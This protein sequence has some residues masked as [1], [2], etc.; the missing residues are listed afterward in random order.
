[1]LPVT[2]ELEGKYLPNLPTKEWKEMKGSY[3]YH[4]PEGKLDFMDHINR[5]HKSMHGEHAK[6]R[7]TLSGINKHI[8][9]N[10]TDVC[11]V[12]SR[13]RPYIGDLF[14]HHVQ[15]NLNGLKRIILNYWDSFVLIQDMSFL[16]SAGV[17]YMYEFEIEYKTL[18]YLSGSQ[19]GDGF[20]IFR[21]RYAPSTLAG[22]T[23]LE[24]SDALSLGDHYGKI[25]SV[26]KVVQELLNNFLLE[27]GINS[28]SCC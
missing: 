12:Y 19:R 2:L 24:E 26:V 16:P 17:N 13:L 18:G 5:I 7:T 23:M 10:V 15:N 3:S 27:S 8:F 1:M 28:C 11:A 22:F 25:S 14:R 9:K 6:F 4:I 20:Y 21:T